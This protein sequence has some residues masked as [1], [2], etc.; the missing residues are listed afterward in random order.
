MFTI[1]IKL[2]TKI[3]LISPAAGHVLDDVFSND[4]FG[5]IIACKA[6]LTVSVMGGGGNKA[7]LP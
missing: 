1:F 3:S 2:S 6:V 4:E 5:A 7:K